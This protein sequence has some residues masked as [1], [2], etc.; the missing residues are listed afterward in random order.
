MLVRIGCETIADKLQPLAPPVTLSLPRFAKDAG[1]GFELAFFGTLREE[2]ADL[3]AAGAEEIRFTGL[4]KCA[5]L[6]RGTDKWD[7]HCDVLLLEIRTFLDN[8]DR[9]RN[10]LQRPMRLRLD[11][12]R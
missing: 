2:L 10:R 12:E 4:R 5:Q 7:N 9:E 3:R 8:M 11:G 1:N 6:L